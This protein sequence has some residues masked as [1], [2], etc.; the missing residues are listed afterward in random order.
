MKSNLRKCI[1]L[2]VI[3]AVFGTLS[4][5]SHAQASAQISGTVTD[6]SGAVV[7]NAQVLIV[8]QDTG[9]NRPATTGSSGEFVAPALDPG[10][11]RI[12]VEAPGFATLVTEGIKLT[13][14]AKQSYH[15]TLKIGKAE[16]SVTVTSEG[17]LINTTTADISSVVAENSI[18]ELPLNGRDPSSLVLL[19]A[20]V[21]NVLNTP[22]GTN[23]LAGGLPTETGASAGGG[24][25][26]STYYMLDGVPNMD[27]FY[28]LAAPFPN[29]D[30]TQEFRVTTN[31]YDAQ[32]GYSPGAIVTIQ[33]KSGTN[34]FH[35][36]LFEFLRNNDLNAGNYF[37]HA[38]DPLKRNQFGGGAGGPI[39]KDKLFFFA[40]YQGTRAST[41]SSSNVSFDPTAAMLNGDF[42]AVPTSLGAP[43]A[44]VGG[45]PNQVNPA[46]FSH[47]ALAVVSNL[48]LGED[49]ASGQVNIVLPTAHYSY[50]E[51]TDRL[52]YA[53]NTSQHVSL[54][55][56]LY[57]YSQPA[58]SVHGN[59]LAFVQGSNGRYINEVLSHNWTINSTLVNV[60]SGFWGRLDNGVFGTAETKDGKP[61][62]LSLVSNASDPPGKCD[63][64]FQSVTG[65]FNTP[66]FL[67]DTYHRST[68]GFSDTLNKTI[69]RHLLTTGMNAYHQLAHEES[70]WP[71][72]PYTGTFGS[73][74]GSGLG[75]YLLGDVGLYYQGGGEYNSQMGWQI[76]AF[77]QD[78]FKLRPT[79]TLTAG[80]RWEPTTPPAIEAGH[81]SG[82]YPGQ[83]SQ[84][85]PNAPIGLLFIGDP[86]VPA[87][88]M[89]SDYKQF[90][91]RVGIAWQPPALPHT[92]F[93]V[94]FGLFTSPNQYS[95]Y[96]HMGDMSPFSPTFTLISYPGSPYYV[97]YDN[98]YANFAPTGGMNPFPPFASESYIP[99]ASSPFPLPLGV[100]SMINSDFRLGITQSWN[101]SIQQELPWKM[102]LQLAYVGSE[103]YALATP[104]DLN[105]G[106]YADG[107]NRT[108][109]PNFSNLYILQAIGTSS[110]ESFQ[111]TLT[112]QA[113]HGLQFQTNFTY[114]KAIDTSSQGSQAWVQ[115]VGDPFSMKHNRGNADVNIPLISISSITYETPGLKSWNPIL[116]N[117]LGD[118][119]LSAIITSQSGVPVNIVG[120]FGNNNSEAQV[121]GD[122]A[123]LTGKPFQVRQGG[124]SKW[125]NQYFNT[126]AFV[127]NAPGTFG[128]SPRNPFQAPPI[129]TVDTGIFKNWKVRERYGIQFRWE[130]FNALNHASFA[131][132]NNDP[133]VPATF[134]TITAVGP[135]AP[136]V[137][138]GALKFSF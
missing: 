74:T 101:A 55:S 130:M 124:K 48:P 8:S 64:N 76:G 19:T 62:C 16:Q 28:L 93:R 104:N 11:Y 65:G 5:V 42:S 58:Q 110:Y 44:T 87:G 68:W 67:P 78:Q 109:Y 22:A 21:S 113:S 133:S 89:N 23:Y 132:P 50:D 35:G 88:L 7:P 10:N 52:D 137:M 86:G 81:G 117:V 56:F 105:P 34:K 125:L 20:G 84:R 63:L 73:F 92:A 3:S 122:R 98:P 119:E 49:P 94:G 57:D 61:F 134:G 27:F 39:F 46:L 43:F 99:P 60:F 18:K 103:S 135:I 9:I 107:G 36:V 51:D 30:A 17:E 77:V 100:S 25:Q 126:A 108:K 111:G 6:D 114:S 95:E 82:F 85:F 37:T 90:V 123:D 45:K 121:G 69:G 31:N 70:G 75:D 72:S 136:R 24:R 138:Q 40:N 26:G 120:G 1:V 131:P 79:L 112:K 14:G 71:Q 53:I 2:V 38:V 59:F 13:V 15:F 33:T 54:R 115:A 29:A 106:V 4:T 91:P 66:E 128:T 80:V 32:Y 47:A 116:S 12:T 83:H 97:S 41:G 118:W 129:N 96:N 102:A 127:P